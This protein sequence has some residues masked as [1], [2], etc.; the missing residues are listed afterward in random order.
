MRALI[1]AGIVV[2]VAWLVWWLVR[3]FGLLDVVVFASV[4]AT[5]LFLVACAVV[6]LRGD[7]QHG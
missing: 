2:V 3:R 7:A 5:A 6:V 1:A 4:G